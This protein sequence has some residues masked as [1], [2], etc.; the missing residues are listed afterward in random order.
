MSIAF[1]T[2]R[3]WGEEQALRYLDDREA[4]CQRVAIILG[5]D[6]RATRS[7]RVYDGLSTDG[8]SC[9]IADGPQKCPVL[10]IS[11]VRNGLDKWLILGN[12]RH[13]TPP[14]GCWWMALIPRDLNLF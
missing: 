6:E 3:E 10:E 7:A 11:R 14:R 9:S 12:L 4:C 13:N 8:T 1:Y 2:T 5:W